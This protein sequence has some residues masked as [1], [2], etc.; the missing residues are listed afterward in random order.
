[1]GYTPNLYRNEWRL[2]L[3]FFQPSMKQK[4]RIKNTQTGKSKRR[5]HKAETP[6]QRLMEHPETT[7]E[8]K[9]MLLSIYKQL[10]PIKLQEQIKHK[11]GLLERSLKS[12]F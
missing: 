11:I 2:Y 5:Y 3:N 8:Q 10:N 4:E 6:Y 1:M 12:G 7:Q 9:D